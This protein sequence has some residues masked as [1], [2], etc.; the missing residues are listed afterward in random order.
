M[1]TN[2]TMLDLKELESKLD[3]ALERETRLSLF[4]W[5]NFKRAKSRLSKLINFNKVTPKLEGKNNFYCMEEEDLGYEK[6]CEQ[7]EACEKHI[8]LSQS[9]VKE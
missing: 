9:H 1:R 4:L 2:K 6:C 3:H 7:C 8:K 5:L